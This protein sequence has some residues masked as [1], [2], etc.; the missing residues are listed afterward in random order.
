MLFVEQLD[1]AARRE[2]AIDGLGGF[3]IAAGSEPG[4]GLV[5]TSAIACVNPRKDR[6]LIVGE[7]PPVQW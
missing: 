1:R 3:L 2:A 4:L 5:R 6:C 7:C